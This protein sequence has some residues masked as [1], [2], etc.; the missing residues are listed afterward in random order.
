V[1]ILC[2][3][4]KKNTVQLLDVCLVIFNDLRPRRIF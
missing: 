3:K 4:Y 1:P 2:Q